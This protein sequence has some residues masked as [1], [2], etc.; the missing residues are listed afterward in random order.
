[1]ATI[2]TSRT[3]SRTVGC[4][5]WVP[6]FARGYVRDLRVRWMLE[7]L[8]ETYRVD[9]VDVRAKPATMAAK[10]PF[11][12][13]PW[14]DDGSVHLF[15]SGAICLW[16]AQ[17]SGQMLGATDA[18][19]ALAMSWVFAALNT[20]EPITA[21]L[22]GVELFHAGEKWTIARRPQ[23]IAA[24]D[25]RI[26][27]LEE[28]LKGREWLDQHFTVGDLMMA[29]VLRDIASEDYLDRFPAV[30]GYRDRCLARPAFQRAIDAQMADFKPEDA[31]PPE[32]TAA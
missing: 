3:P 6:G 9:P 31:H 30:R 8:G 15:E 10:Q 19:S 11:K 24:M 2:T 14:Y 18:E 21:Q 27:A 13:V 5:D 25:Q 23:V 7:E 16:L 26:G 1:M 28:H 20:I 29:C 12:Q 17:Q 32:M 22:A 4:Y